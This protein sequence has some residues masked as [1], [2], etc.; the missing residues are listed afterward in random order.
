[1]ITRDISMRHDA[2]PFLVLSFFLVCTFA[3]IPFPCHASDAESIENIL[4]GFEDAKSQEDDLQDIMDAFEEKDTFS[5]DRIFDGFEDDNGDAETSGKKNEYL[6]SFLSMDGYL[7]LGSSYNFAH[8]KP[9]AGQTDWRGLSRLRAE[10]QV[11]LEAKFSASWKAFISGKGTYD[12]AYRINGRDQYT[13]DVLDNYEK[14]LELRETYLSGSLLESLDIKTGRQIVVWGKSDNIRVTDVLNPLDNREPGLTDLEDLR[15][16]VFMT[17]LSY[18]LNKWSLTGIAVHEIRFAKNPEYGSDFYPSPVPYPHED[19]PS[20]GGSNTE[21]AVSLSGIFS[22][23]D[24][25]FYW[26]DIFD[27]TPHVELQS[28]DLDV[29]S[30]S[31]LQINTETRV[32]MKHARVKMYGADVN[33]A[34]GNWLIKIEAAWFDGM[35]FFNYPHITGNLPDT[36]ITIQPGKKYSRIDTLGG[37]EY[38]GFKNTMMSLEMVNRHL[39]DYEVEQNELQ[40]VVRVAKNFLNDTFLLEVI[41]SWYA[42]SGGSFQR[43]SAEYDITDNTKIIGGTALYQSGDHAGFTNIDDNDRIFLEGKFSF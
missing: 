27:D 38:S 39:R 5:D 42:R 24:I 41:A 32:E 4:D 15:L 23:W 20:H 31:P 14:E 7:K 2:Y 18:Y 26:A 35:Q 16:P 21:Y 36:E 3:L 13:D 37:I 10:L 22:G 8:K 9:D 34:F 33:A 25:A 6:P 30:V 29:V 19:K 43:F 11:E 17:R 12:F 28:L 40:T 1:M